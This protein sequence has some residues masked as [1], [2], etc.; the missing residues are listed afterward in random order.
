MLQKYD[1]RLRDHVYTISEF[2]LT[3]HVLTRSDR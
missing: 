3:S 2:I 1:K